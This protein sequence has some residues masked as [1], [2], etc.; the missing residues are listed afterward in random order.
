MWT[1]LLH[2]MG[3]PGQL[4]VFMENIYKEEKNLNS[5]FESLLDVPFNPVC[6]YTNKPSVL[7]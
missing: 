2:S 7:L 6:S 4:G 1:P 3:G 5:V